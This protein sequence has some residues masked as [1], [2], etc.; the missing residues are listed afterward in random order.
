[1]HHTFSHIKGL[2]TLLDHGNATEKI[3]LSNISLP[4]EKIYGSRFFSDIQTWLIAKGKYKAT[5]TGYDREYKKTKNGH[6][7]GGAL[8]MLW[9]E[10]A[11]PIFTASMNE[12]Q[13]LEAP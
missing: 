3:S 1:V 6:A 11:G 12:Y 5:V 2:T 9:H 10:K 4:R 7:T 13:L 8:T